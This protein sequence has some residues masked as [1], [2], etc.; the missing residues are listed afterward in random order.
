MDFW[1]KENPVSKATLRWL[2]HASFLLRIGGKTLWLDPWIEGNPKCPISLSRVRKADYVCVTHGHPD[3][4]GDAITICR[5]TKAKLVC[6]PEIAQYAQASAG[7][8]YDRASR[9]LNTGGTLRVGKLR[10][11]MVHAVHPSDLWAPD[12][13]LL[14]G[15]G[16]CG[17]VIAM[18]G[19]PSVYY[20]GDTN[21]FSDMTL[22]RELHQPHVAI[23]PIGGKY[24]MGVREA[25]V[26]CR[27]LAPAKFV[28]MH[29]DT[30]PDQA[31][32]TREL[33]RLVNAQSPTTDLVVMKLG[34][35]VAL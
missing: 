21:V 17:Y 31:A 9:P 32:D 34:Q 2:G 7:L 10:I 22:I 16:C 24:T 15:S 14:T 27:L 4:L 23:M 1:S 26:A 30:F 11:T 33:R 3:H 19:R 25:A 20:A 8:V 13:G 28:P 6:T 18:A 35:T 12:G 29:Y 5:R